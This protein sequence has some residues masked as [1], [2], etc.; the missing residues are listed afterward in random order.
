MCEEGKDDQRFQNYLHEFELLLDE[1][2][3]R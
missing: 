3:N 1:K 2:R